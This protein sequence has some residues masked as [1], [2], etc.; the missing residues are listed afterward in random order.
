MADAASG[1]AAAAAGGRLKAATSLTTESRP[2]GLIA[3][4]K[5]ET[6][7][8]SGGGAK[9]AHSLKA[10]GKKPVGTISS[11]AASAE[12]KPSAAPSG[13]AAVKPAK[14]KTWVRIRPLAKEGEKGHTDGAAVEKQL[15]AFDEKAVKII[16]HDM[17]GKEVVYDYPSTV[18]PV[19]CTQ[20]D[21]GN[22]V[23]PGMLADFWGER[24]GMIFAYGQ[25]GTGKTT[26]MFGFPESLTSESE[27]PGWGLLPRAVHA[28]LER[29]AE[30]AKEGV[31][32]LLLLSAVE[33]YCFLAYDL[34]N[35]AG[36]QMCTMKG[37]Q[38][39][40]NTYTQ[41]DSPAILKD[42]IE[43]VYGNRKVVATKMN[44]GSSRSHCAITLTL[45]TH[46]TGTRSFRETTF[47]IVDLAGAERPEKALGTRISKDKAMIE[48][49]MYM[50]DPVLKDLSPGAQGFLINFELTMLLT[51]I[52]AA[53]DMHKAGKQ[54]KLPSTVGGGAIHFLGGACTGEARM[55][56]LICLS[57]SPQHGWE[58]WFSI[59]NYGKQLSE[60]KTRV[61][62]V[63]TIPMAK[64]LQ[65]AEAASQ[66]AVDDL[67]KAGTSA[68]SMKF[69][70]YRVGM[71]VYTEQRLHFLQRLS[72]M[73]GDGGGGAALL[74]VDGVA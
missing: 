46:D 55:G 43:R 18:F 41:C 71:Q 11:S 54:F 6:A 48:L 35:K 25:T 49:M 72:K 5:Q 51:L 52:A 56:A 33:F 31:R 59:A 47:S 24:S 15:G 69:L 14:I 73:G 63:K 9:A 2:N 16:N 3:S 1:R 70:A 53:S 29:I 39:L 38:V 68:S 20:E 60:L 21:V 34:A 19:T 64:A 36:K 27:D 74:T 50:R 40:G 62:P 7:G 26:T 12:K 22:D 37:G 8:A 61:V 45:L 30:R 17:K 57:Q 13:W 4:A 65:E 10:D 28:T 44:D 66:S 32:S 23:L 58:T 42:F 67:A